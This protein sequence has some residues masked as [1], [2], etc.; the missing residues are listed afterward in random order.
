MTSILFADLVKADLT[1]VYDLRVIINNAITGYFTIN[2][3]LFPVFYQL[4]PHQGSCYSSL[5]QFE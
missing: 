2:I 3:M 4:Y 5:K 1:A